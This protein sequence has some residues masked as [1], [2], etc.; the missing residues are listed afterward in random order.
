MLFSLYNLQF[1]N[2]G[3][4]HSLIGFESLNPFFYSHIEYGHL[5]VWRGGGQWPQNDSC[6]QAIEVPPLFKMGHLHCMHVKRGRTSIVRLHQ[7]FDTVN[8]SPMVPLVFNYF[9]IKNVKS[10]YWYL[11]VYAIHKELTHKF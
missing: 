4:F 1:K 9:K 5:C 7:I 3:G 11:W 2:L 6:N 10:F 8:A